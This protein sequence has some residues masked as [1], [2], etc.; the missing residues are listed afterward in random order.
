MGWVGCVGAGALT[1]EA[2]S[3]SCW[4]LSCR[5]THAFQLDILARVNGTM[6]A[7]F[8]LSHTLGLQMHVMGCSAVTGMFRT[9]RAG[10]LCSTKSGS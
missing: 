10:E 9:N 3:M 8:R 4:F 7:S 6:P 2:T 1:R 5:Y